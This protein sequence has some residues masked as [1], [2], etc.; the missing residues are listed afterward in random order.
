M[1]T[2][3]CQIVKTTLRE[4]RPGD[5]MLSNFR[6]YYKTTVITTARYWHKSRFIAQWNRLQNLEIN[7]YTYCQLIYGKGD[8]N[9]QWRKD[10]R[11][12]RAGKTG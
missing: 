9:I 4:K 7:P 3:G 12:N 8:K 1:G 2:K 6:L 5:I 10:S 11:F